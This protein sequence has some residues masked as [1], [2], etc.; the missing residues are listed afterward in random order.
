[1][2]RSAFSP[3]YSKIGSSL[4]LKNIRPYTLLSCSSLKQT[5]KK[6]QIKQYR[7]NTEEKKHFLVFTLSFSGGALN[8]RMHEISSGV[9]IEENVLMQKQSYLA[10]KYAENT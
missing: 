2:S 3:L 6:I 10:S 7:N 1:M 4:T 5:F 8:G 9:E